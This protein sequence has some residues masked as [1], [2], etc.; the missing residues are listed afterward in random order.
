MVNA[1]FF[2]HLIIIVLFI[3][4]V[5]CFFF[6]N[7]IDFNLYNFIKYEDI[8]FI[9]ELFMTYSLNWNRFFEDSYFFNWF[10]SEVVDEAEV[11][12]FFLLWRQ[13]MY[14]SE[15]SRVYDLRDVS[16]FIL[17]Y[18]TTSGLSL[19]EY[20][21]EHED[22]DSLELFNNLTLY[23][24]YLEDFRHI[25]FDLFSFSNIF[26][27]GENFNVSVDVFTQL[28]YRLFNI[29]YIFFTTNVT[30][31]TIIFVFLT[32]LVFF[33]VWFYA[34]CVGVSLLECLIYL[35]I[36]FLSFLIFYVDNLFFFIVILELTTVLLLFTYSGDR[37]RRFRAMSMLFYY[38]LAS[39]LF[40][41]FIYL[42]REVVVFSTDFDNLIFFVLML[43]GIAIKLPVFPFHFWLPEAHAEATTCG[44]LILAGVILKMGFYGF[45]LFIG[46]ELFYS[47]CKLYII[48]ILLFSSIFLLAAIYVQ[49]DIKKIIAYSSVV[50]MQIAM[51][52]YLMD[53]PYA[54]EAALLMVINHGLVSVGLFVVASLFISNEGTRDII[55]WSYSINYL[56]KIFLC[57]ILSNMSFPF[58]IG[59]WGEFLG[60]S[61]ALN[62]SLCVF[63]LFIVNQ[64]VVVI[65]NLR[66][67]W[68]VL[69]VNGP[70]YR[71]RGQINYKVTTVLILLL[72]FNLAFFI[73]F[74]HFFN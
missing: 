61:V 34:F 15:Y 43:I 59:F 54:F 56:S 41:L 28:F 47:T 48:M 51:S 18:I 39:G 26:F 73:F 4:Y 45:V 62:M 72:L 29:N 25:N 22:L 13:F 52:V 2:G 37:Y 46:N 64:L 33:V 32:F 5:L 58:T 40:L 38:T 23:V 10:L 7:H 53:A 69:S 17:D 21:F 30:F 24:N 44:S 70:Y 55:K 57:F 1:V 16:F 67:Y 71:L 12:N 74:F 31:L 9:H 14:V 36:E 65:Y 6:F 20:G 3:L 27:F 42:L 63:F 68:L 60:I 50:H 35:F 49:V 19:D 11:D 8:A 66:F